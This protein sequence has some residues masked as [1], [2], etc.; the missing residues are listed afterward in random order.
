MKKIIL[1]I[2]PIILLGCSKVATLNTEYLKLNYPE[3]WTVDTENKL[4]EQPGFERI[5]ATYI[6]DMGTESQFIIN[7]EPADPENSIKEY[8]VMTKKLLTENFEGV[9]FVD[10]TDTTLD[11]ARTITLIH[12]NAGRYWLQSWTDHNDLVYTITLATPEAQKDIS[13]TQVDTILKG[14][15]LK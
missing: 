9:E 4:A 13:M 12:N 11:E 1:L 6:F 10:Q 7:V 8:R 5:L 15:D 3:S 14:I 2:L